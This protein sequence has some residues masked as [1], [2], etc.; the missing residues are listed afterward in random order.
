MI[1]GLSATFNSCNVLFTTFICSSYWGCDI[2]T[3]Q[4]QVWFHRTSS[5][6]LLKLS[7]RWCGSFRMKPTGIAQRNGVFSKQLCVWWCRAWRT[8][9]FLRRLH[10]CSIPS[11]KC[12]CQRWYNQPI[13]PDKF[14]TVFSL[15]KALPVDIKSFLR[16]EIF[17][18]TIRRSVSISCFS[19]PLVPIPPYSR[20]VSHIL[21]LVLAANIGIGQSSTCTLACA[22]LARLKMS[23]IRSFYL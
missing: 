6:V 20:G 19:G 22:V 11:L 21:L 1:T 7:T 2:S 18:F 12:F 15:V 17:V 14:A 23:R 3:M 4:Q 8:I 16:K 9:C 13:P 5:S 10:F